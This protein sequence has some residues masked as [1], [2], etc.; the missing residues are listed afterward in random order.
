MEQAAAET[1]RTEP[2]S[3]SLGIAAWATRLPALFPQFFPIP[4][5]IHDLVRQRE[6]E[7]MRQH[8]HLS[9][10]VGF[11]RKHVAQH[12]RANRPWPSPAVSEKFLDTAPTPAECFSEHLPA[13]SSALGQSRT[14][15][16]RRAVRT[17]KLS[18]NLKVR[19]GKPHPLRA[20]VVHVRENRRDGA[21]LAG[22]FG[23]PGGRVKMFDKH[24]VH[25]LISSKYLDSGSAQLSVNQWRVNLLSQNLLLTLG[26]GSLPLDLCIFQVRG[27]IRNSAE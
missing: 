5:P 3:D 24:L 4:D 1:G 7:L 19:S 18:W 8:T 2:L 20:D 17:G 10:M 12:L 27:Q 16:P 21:G 13:A 11:V 23:S 22:R 9:A 26:H 6:S 25:A 15:L 14:G